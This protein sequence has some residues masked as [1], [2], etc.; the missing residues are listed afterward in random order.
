MCHCSP[1][2]AAYTS[3]TLPCLAAPSSPPQP[4]SLLPR[5][6]RHSPPT[7]AS[8]R[9][10]RSSPCQ[11]QY[12]QSPQAKQSSSTPTAQ[13]KHAEAKREKKREQTPSAKN[14]KHSQLQAFHNTTLCSC[15][16]PRHYYMPR[17]PRIS[18]AP[19]PAPPPSSAPPTRPP[20]SIHAPLTAYHRQPSPSS[21][22]PMPAAVHPQPP[23][24][25]VQQH[26]HGEAHTCG[27]KQYAKQSVSGPA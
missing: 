12:T 13:P 21:I 15:T 3:H 11:P 1:P 17:C 26:T 19:L 14:Y 18:H 27:S 22:V 10:R 8:H 23:S 5:Y 7:I 24:Q 20:P 9:H 2:P 25:A 16:L 4:P 6:T